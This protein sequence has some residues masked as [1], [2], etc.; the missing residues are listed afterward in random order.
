MNS[1]VVLGATGS[2]GRQTLDV[3]DKLGMEV[4]GLAARSAGKDLAEIAG[5]Y[6]SALIVAAEPEPRQAEAF[7]ERFGDR[8]ASGA[9]ALVELARLDG[10]TVVNGVVGAAGLRASLAALSAGNRLALA[11]KESLVA[12]GP[13]VLKAASTGGGELLPVDSEHSALFQCLVGEDPADVRRLVLTASGGP[14]RGRSREDLAGVSPTEALAHPTWDMGPRIT[15]DS[16]TLVNKGLEVIEA[17]FLFDM[18]YDQID[19]VVHPQ[20]IVHSLVE[21]VDGSLK[22]H[23]GQPDMAVPIQYAL[24]YPRRAPGVLGPFPLAGTTLEFGRPD[25]VAFPALELAY[26]AG[27][28]GGTAPAMFN[29]ADEIAVAA[30]LD[31]DIGFLDIP[32]TIESVLDRLPVEPVVDV[33]GVV[34]ADAAARRAAREWIGSR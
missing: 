27:R 33:E 23:V 30:F 11:N 15:V 29:A 19:V 17:H 4:A 14:F 21:F 1:L 2:I 6:P 16:A 13:L 5:R 10:A 28:A 22:A 31:G 24:T 9:E 20:S 26:A 3:A 25:R 7:G 8:F 18:T 34:A 12:A 32:A